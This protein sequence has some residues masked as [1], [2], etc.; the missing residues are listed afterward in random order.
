MSNAPKMASAFRA[1]EVDNDALKDGSWIEF[2]WFDPELGEKVV[3]GRFLCLPEHEMLN[4]KWRRAKALIRRDTRLYCKK[5]D[6][7]I[8]DTV[9]QLEEMEPLPYE[10]E[11]M[12]NSNHYFGSV[13]LDYELIDLDGETVPVNRDTFVACMT[14]MPELWQKLRLR[15]LKLATFHREHEDEIVKD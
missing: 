11:M 9:E 4:P 2:D 15:C 10:V 8:P 5:N 6:I 13:V 3:V 12:L 14:C 1:Y 7:S